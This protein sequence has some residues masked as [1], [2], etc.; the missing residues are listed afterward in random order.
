MTAYNPGDKYRIKS[1]TNPIHSDGKSIEF[2]V[3]KDK[4]GIFL[5]L[6]DDWQAVIDFDG[7]LVSA[8]LY[9]IERVFE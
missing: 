8:D 1:N 7:L 9:D 6:D 4:V 5:K 2:N 3:V